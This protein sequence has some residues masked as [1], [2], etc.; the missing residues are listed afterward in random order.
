MLSRVRSSTRARGVCEA[1]AYMRHMRI[2]IGGERQIGRLSPVGN[3]LRRHKPWIFYVLGIVESIGKALG[4]YSIRRGTQPGEPPLAETHQNRI[5]QM[6][7]PVLLDLDVHQGWIGVCNDVRTRGGALGPLV[8]FAV[9]F[10]HVIIW[11]ERM[12]WMVIKRVTA[13]HSNDTRVTKCQEA[14][15]TDKKY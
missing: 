2:G 1:G 3:S 10:I 8:E 13:W 14:I 7:E 9:D 6:S 11:L 15:Y 4:R 5:H 12:K